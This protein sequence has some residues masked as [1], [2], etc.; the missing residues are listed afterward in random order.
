MA[1]SRKVIITCAVTGAAHTP[2]MSPHLPI[3]PDE[4]ADQA[5]DAA[6]AGAAIVHF[7]ARNP[8]DGRPTPDPDVYAPVIERVSAE[9]DVVINIT[10]SGGAKTTVA[11]RM[12]AALR[13]KPELASLNMGSLSPY[14][15][16]RILEKFDAWQHEW[17]RELFTAAPSRVYPNTEE[18]ISETIRQV[19]AGGTRFECEC[20]DVGHLYNVAYFAEIGLLKPPFIIQTVFGFSGGIGLA[21]DHVTHMRGVADRLFGQDYHWSVLAPGKH[22]FR[23]CTMG[24]TMGSNVRVGMEDNLYL[25]RG[26]MAR[27]NAEQVARMR[28]ILT[29]LGLD[30]ATPAEARQ[31]LALKGRS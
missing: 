6:T 16:Q 7:H 8:E 23:L 1:T 19:G 21:A 17:E 13:F 31:I 5:I 3:T 28:D 9:T 22:Q 11:D 10:T 20:Y 18:M 14:G 27:S 26:R 30:V 29:L 24:A 15:R 4:I 12:A 25:E 2:T